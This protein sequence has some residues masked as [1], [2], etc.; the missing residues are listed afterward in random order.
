MSPTGRD[1][2]HSEEDQGGNEISP[3]P[4]DRLSAE[5][6][7]QTLWIT[8]E[9]GPEEDENAT[10]DIGNHFRLPSKERMIINAF[11]TTTPKIAHAKAVCQPTELDV[12]ANPSGS[13]LTS[14]CAS[15]RMGSGRLWPSGC[16]GRAW[17]R[18]PR[19]VLQE[20]AGIKSGDV[21]LPARGRDREPDKRIRLRCVTTPDAAQ[22]VLLN[23]LGLT[24]PQRLRRI[25]EIA[26]M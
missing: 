19:T 9:E 14:W 21:I 18:P 4:A 3:K 13:E 15:R 1:Q 12:G 8:P 2:Q 20:F 17:A 16:T 24:L 23:R 25:D 22:K 5:A 11:P 26:Q 6:P 7:S 10:H